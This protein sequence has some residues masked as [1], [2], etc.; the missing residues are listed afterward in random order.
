MTH[1]LLLLQYFPDRFVRKE[2]NKIP[3]ECSNMQHGCM[4]T[5][6]YGEMKSHIQECSFGRTACLYCNQWIPTQ[7][8]PNTYINSI[9]RDLAFIACSHTNLI[10]SLINNFTC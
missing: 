5:G 9:V 8:V 2:V 7:Q 6:R 4:W 1:I 3:V 10:T